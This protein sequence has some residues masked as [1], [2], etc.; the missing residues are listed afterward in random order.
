MIK[1]DS[2]TRRLYA[3]DASLYEEFPS[4]VSFPVYCG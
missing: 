1:T 2:L 3:T 4:G